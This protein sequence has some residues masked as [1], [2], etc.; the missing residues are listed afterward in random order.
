MDS[1]ISAM[2][3]AQAAQQL[4]TTALAETLETQQA[5]IAVILQSLELIS[6][7]QASMVQATGKGAQI[8]VSI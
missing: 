3:Q 6:E 5:D 1:V 8:D 2:T 4:Q 7:M